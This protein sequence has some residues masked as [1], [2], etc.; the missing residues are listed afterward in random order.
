M[1]FILPIV[2]NQQIALQERTGIIMSTT[3]IARCFFFFAVVVFFLNKKLK[4]KL[5]SKICSFTYP[6]HLPL[7]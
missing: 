4:L 7:Q 2:T 1:S 6:D 5:K 3:N